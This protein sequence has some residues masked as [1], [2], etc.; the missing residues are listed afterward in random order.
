ML[1]EGEDLASTF[2]ILQQADVIQIADG[3]EGL[4]ALLHLA[5]QVEVAHPVAVAAAGFCHPLFGGQVCRETDQEGQETSVAP[6]EAVGMP[7]ATRTTA[8]QW[9]QR[10]QPFSLRTDGTQTWG[11]PQG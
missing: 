11:V 8:T 7:P 1:V 9:A 6:G 2:R 3:G 5:A 4:R 10:Q